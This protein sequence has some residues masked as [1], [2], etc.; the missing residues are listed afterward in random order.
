ML[1]NDITR[2]GKII[3]IALVGKTKKFGIVD[4]ERVK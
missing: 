1:K 2:I 3:K 4:C